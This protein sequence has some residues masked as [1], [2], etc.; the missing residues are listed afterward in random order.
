MTFKFKI[1]HIEAFTKS[2]CITT[3]EIAYSITQTLG[4]GMK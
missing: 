1:K 4:V 2:R 3:S